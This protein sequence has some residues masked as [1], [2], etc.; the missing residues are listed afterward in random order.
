MR[1]QDLL[2][3][4]KNNF[5]IYGFPDTSR[6]L[7][8]VRLSVTPA[9]RK[10]TYAN[11]KKSAA[12]PLPIDGTLRVSFLCCHTLTSSVNDRAAHAKRLFVDV[13]QIG[14]LFA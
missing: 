13:Q 8:A 3:K 7:I 11:R 1:W 9:K 2:K 10:R 5:W 4:G 6:A 14:F 12:N